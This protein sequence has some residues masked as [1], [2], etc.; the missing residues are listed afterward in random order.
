VIES[1][2]LRVG[3]GEER[4]RLL[5]E[6]AGRGTLGVTETEEGIEAFF[7]GRFDASFLNSYEPVWVGERSIDWVA[8]SRAGM[9]PEAV[10]ERLFLVPDWLD[11]AAPEGR[12]RLVVH[13]GQASGS[14]YSDPTRLALEALER[15]LRGGEVV[16]D[17]GTGS[18]ILT[19]AAHLLGA[20]RLLACE[21]DEDAAEHAKANL[22]DVP[23]MLWVGSPRSLAG[24]VA[25][26]VVANLNGETILALDKELRRVLHPGGVM[27]LSGIREKRVEEV[28][29][30]FADLEMLAQAAR[31]QW[32]SL[33]FMR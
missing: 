10:G 21:I 7:E 4:E 27:V 14:G 26:L 13:A 23:A 16:L 29:G 24:G 12:L 9:E 22:R 2:R 15:H 8:V 3:E 31:G 32:R 11:A 1:L 20:G 5:A 19:A 30:A 25:D 28:R 18:G 6:L 33:A 17:V